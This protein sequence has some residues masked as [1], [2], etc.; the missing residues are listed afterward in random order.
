M[1]IPLCGS[2]IAGVWGIV[3]RCI[4]LARAH[5]TDTG[6]AVLAVF[7]PLIVCC[8]GGLL[9]A[10]LFGGIGALSHSWNH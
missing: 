10:I 5:E 6:R 2:V 4:G 8:G 3:L 1:I 9:L 7:L